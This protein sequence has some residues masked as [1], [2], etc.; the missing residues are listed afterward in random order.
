M[1]KVQDMKDG[2]HNHDLCSFGPWAFGNEYSLDTDLTKSF[3][4]LGL[5]CLNPAFCSMV[6]HAMQEP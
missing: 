2:L 6:A 3:T 5:A 1:H 4:M